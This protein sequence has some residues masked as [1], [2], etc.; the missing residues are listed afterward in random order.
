M[1]TGKKKCYHFVRTSVPS[2]K[3]FCDVPWAALYLCVAARA[4]QWKLP[5]E[6]L[7]TSATSPLQCSGGSSLCTSTLCL[8]FPLHYTALARVCMTDTLVRC[9]MFL[10][11]WISCPQQQSHPWIH[12]CRYLVIGSVFKVTP[13]VTL[14]TSDLKTK[15]S[16]RI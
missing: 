9:I 6:Q 8:P 14:T 16:W 2:F 3:P 13:E 11:D 7:C 5:R 12:R 10:W 1:K 4:S 15:T